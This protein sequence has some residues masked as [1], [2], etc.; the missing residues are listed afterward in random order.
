MLGDVVQKTS[1]EDVCSEWLYG[2]ETPQQGVNDDLF[3]T[4]SHAV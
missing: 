3:Y 4:S 1:D 2:D